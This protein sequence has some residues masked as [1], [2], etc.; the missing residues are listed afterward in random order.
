[1]TGRVA[2]HQNG[3]PGLS[4]WEW[5]ET[6]VGHLAYCQYLVLLAFLVGSGL[7]QTLGGQR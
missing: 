6:R 1:M 3:S 7:K 2:G 5:I 4:G